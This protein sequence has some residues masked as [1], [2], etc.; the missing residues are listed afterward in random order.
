MIPSS[1]ASAG[2]CAV[3]G[4]R[5][6]RV[7]RGP[8]GAVEPIVE[9]TPPA[10]AGDDGGSDAHR[11]GETVWM[12]DGGAGDDAGARNADCRC[13]CRERS[14]RSLAVAV[15]RDTARSGRGVGRRRALGRTGGGRGQRGGGPM[16][17][18]DRL[19][20][21]SHGPSVRG[22]EQAPVHAARAHTRG[23]V[24]PTPR[25]RWQLRS[26]G[27]EADGSDTPR[28]CPADRERGKGRAAEPRVPGGPS[29]PYP[30]GPRIPSPAGTTA[31]RASGSLPANRWRTRSIEHRYSRPA[32]TSRGHRRYTPGAARPSGP[33]GRPGG[34]KKEGRRPLCPAA[35]RSRWTPIRAACSPV[36]GRP[37]P[38]VYG[39]ARVA[40]SR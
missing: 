27:R 10:D 16:R 26:P 34:S 17:A 12:R 29:A 15:Q 6:G 9:R 24:R 3:A 1:A 13:R 8:R 5:H 40:V 36:P 21:A 20:A 37:L 22:G 25:P 39:R 38:F 14:R 18:L 19:G 30:A 28:S 2:W 23:A 31:S 11:S 32:C 35:G 33:P 4:K 7:R